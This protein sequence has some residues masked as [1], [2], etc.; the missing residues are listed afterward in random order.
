MNKLMIQRLFFLFFCFVSCIPYIF[1][2]SPGGVETT[3][4]KDMQRL[5]ERL[6]QGKQGSIIAIEPA[7][8]AIKCM[9]SSS[10][11]A[12]DVNRAIGTTYSPASTF[13][14]AQALT[15]LSE[16]IISPE[17]WYSCHKGFW[18]GKVHIG[19]HPHHS[20]EKLNGALTHSCNSYFC[21]A[22]MAMIDNRSR[23]KS[24]NEALTTWHDYMESMGLGT[25][26]GVDIPGEKSG[27]VPDVSFL[28]KANN[29]RWN[30]QTIMW[31]GMGQG[32]ITTTPLQLCNLAASIANRGF[33]YIPHFYKKSATLEKYQSKHVTKATP[34]AYE[35]VILGMRTAVTR[36]TCKAL[37]TPQ[38]K[39]CGKTGTAEN[40]GEDHSVFIGFAP[41]DNPKIAVSVYVEN[42]G[43]GADMAAPMAALMIEQYLNKNLS[44]RSER[45][46]E[47][48]E[49]Y[50]IMPETE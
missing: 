24:R 32:E 34:K 41:M 9:V 27:T 28:N 31:V 35:Q 42:G 26:L 3:A 23:Y 50:Y 10:Y 38:Y 16:Y 21:K 2:V 39:V 12:D 20:P 14:T 48:W 13:K 44:H 8:G 30:A 5:A 25:A 6:L 29:N 37:D 47:Q 33:Y 45:K 18:R 36:G 19:C 15:L 43:F 7:T 4:D 46:V 1:A 49:E 11:L 17:T 22:F 40:S